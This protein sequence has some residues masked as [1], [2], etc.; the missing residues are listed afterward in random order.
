MRRDARLAWLNAQYTRY[1]YHD[2]NDMP[3]DPGVAEAGSARGG[4]ADRAYV[5]AWMKAMAARTANGN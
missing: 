4:E 2:P 3:D 1:A 5:R